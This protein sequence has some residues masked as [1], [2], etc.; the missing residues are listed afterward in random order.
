[1]EMTVSK[2]PSTGGNFEAGI[3]RV[4]EPQ[5][6]DEMEMTTAV[7]SSMMDSLISQSSEKPLQVQD[8]VDHLKDRKTTEDSPSTPQEISLDVEAEN[9]LEKEQKKSPKSAQET[10]E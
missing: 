10:E 5:S 8:D 7:K 1:M 6:S 9:L 2:I 4:E 3:Q